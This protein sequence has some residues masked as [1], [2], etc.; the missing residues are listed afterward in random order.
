MWNSPGPPALSA[1]D[2][3]TIFWAHRLENPVWVASTCTPRHL[4]APCSLLVIAFVHS[5]ELEQAESD[6]T[7]KQQAE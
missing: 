5:S 1:A 4:S 3:L 2:Y 7:G 6:T